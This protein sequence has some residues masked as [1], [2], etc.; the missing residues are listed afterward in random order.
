M[1]GSVTLR[2]AAMA[3]AASAALPP[4][5]RISMPVWDASGWLVATIARPAR[6]ID[7]PAGTSAN[8]RSG[9]L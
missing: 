5:F 3:I 9:G 8:Q 4:R 1:W 6:T 7:R 2:T